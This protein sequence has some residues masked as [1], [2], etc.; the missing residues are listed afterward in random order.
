ME[1]LLEHVFRNVLSVEQED[2]KPSGIG[3]WLSKLGNEI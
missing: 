3:Q 1:N 2:S